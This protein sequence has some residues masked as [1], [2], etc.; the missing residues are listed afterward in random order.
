M[1]DGP[2]VDEVRAQAR[3]AVSALRG[4][5]R[6]E[7]VRNAKALVEALRNQ[8]DY[9]LMGQLAEAVSRDDPK[10][11]KN[12]RLYAQYLIDTGKATAAIDLL[13]PLARRLPRND[14]EFGEAAGLPGR[15]WKQMFF[16][17]ADKSSASAREALKNHHKG[18]KAG[19]PRLNG[20]EGTYA[21]NEGISVQSIAAA[22]KG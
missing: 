13:Q 14:P 1:S 15:A 18:G 3:R 8:R 2:S 11:A 10:D 6:D 16:D 22:M 4:P 9:E 7:D 20:K 5:C 21:A 19:M 17:A 12:R